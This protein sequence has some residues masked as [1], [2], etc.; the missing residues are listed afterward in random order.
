[1]TALAPRELAA[2]PAVAVPRP[3]LQRPPRFV[4][5]FN[6]VALMALLCGLTTMVYV[7]WIGRVYVTEL[8]LLPTALCALLSARGQRAFASPVLRSLVLAG[9]LMLCGYVLSD[10]V[11]ETVPKQYLRGWAKSVFQLFDVV[12]LCIIVSADRRNFWWYCFGTALGGI[13]YL[14]GVIHEPIGSW[15]VTYAAPFNLLVLCLSLWL[16]RRFLPLLLLGAA[17]IGLVFD[18]RADPALLLVL[19][20]IL[21]ARGAQGDRPMALRRFLRRLALP[22]G[23]GALVF[24]LIFAATQAR[25]GERRN[26]SSLGRTLSFTLGLRAIAASPVVGYGSWNDNPVVSKL[27]QELM[28]KALG[29]NAAGSIRNISFSP[30]SQ[31]LQSWYEGGLLAA[32]FF[33]V[34]LHWLRKGLLDAALRRTL[35]PLSG[36]LLY[37]MLSGLWHLFMSPF[38]GDHRLRIMLA[39]AALLVVI[40]EQQAARSVP[41]RRVAMRRLP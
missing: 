14:A 5:Q 39:A 25:F 29:P 15:K 31:I 17:L 3:G 16:G 12:C 22:L 20:S 32:A 1:M 18:S 24:G 8:M 27:Q 30:H 41:Q 37:A 36:L 34:L 2:W 35:D 21:W 9:V 19:A 11:R 13:G 4:L 40:G 28:L 33:M 7:E 10:L 26:V 6:V 23:I 38:G